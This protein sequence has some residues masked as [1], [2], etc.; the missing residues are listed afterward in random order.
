MFFSSS[1]S[2]LFLS[3]TCSIL[4]QDRTS[5]QGE[6]A[7]KDPNQ[8]CTPYSYAPTIALKAQFPTIWETAALVSG[9]TTG[10]QKWASIKDSIPTSI[11]IKGTPAGDFSNFTPGYITRG[12]TSG[13]PDPDCWWTFN[14]CTVPKLSGLPTDISTM[15]E[16]NTLGFGFDDGPNCSHNAFYDYL[17][18]QKQKATMFYIGSNV[19]DWPLEAQRA[20]ADGHEICVHTWS[21]QYMTA[22]SSETAFAELWYTMQAVRAAVGVT[23]TCWRP[24]YGDVDDR[25]RS[26]AKALGLRTILWAYDSDDWKNGIENVTSQTVDANYGDLIKAAQNGTFNSAGTIILTHELNNYTM[27][28]AIRQY[29]ALKAAFKNVI[30]VGVGYNVTQPYQETNYTQ[31]S[32]SQYASGQQG[33]T[34]S[35]ASSAL[36]G[37]ISTSKVATKT[38]SS[39]KASASN[40]PAG[41]TNAAI[42]LQLSWIA[43][44]AFIA[45]LSGLVIA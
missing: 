32:F 36:S 9:D 6:A 35:G 4:A 41:T 13:N 21:H 12:Q 10:N 40:T 33:G 24:P 42:S 17:S 18:A 45:L 37:S 34:G 30:P 8:E 5:E 1:T 3:L 20:L 2:I 27:S 38:G 25:I 7:I 39:T 43:T 14:G 31:Q 28:E 11:S 29:P 16:P 26:I 15:P 22:L 19:L 44:M 23:P